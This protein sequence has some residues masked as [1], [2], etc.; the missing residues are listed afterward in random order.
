MWFSNGPPNDC[1]DMKCDHWTECGIKHGGCCALGLFGGRPSLGVCRGCPQN[2]A[3]DLATF[4]LHTN[5]PRPANATKDYAWPVRVRLV[6]RFRRE[7][8]KGV[9][10]TLARMLGQVGGEVWKRW[11]KRLTGQDC[12]CKDRQAKLNAKYRY[13]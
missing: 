1:G 9:G 8:E 10:D 13:H 4:K 3:K 11:Y 5:P 2:S 7:G 12:A 6:G